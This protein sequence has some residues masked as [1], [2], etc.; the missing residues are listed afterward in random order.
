MCRVSAKRDR[1][2]NNTP[3]PTCWVNREERDGEALRTLQF[4]CRILSDFWGKSHKT[5]FG[6][7]NSRL[8]PGG[9]WPVW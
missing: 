9:R 1:D 3:S 5:S 8:A 6:W 2:K 7:E 4:A